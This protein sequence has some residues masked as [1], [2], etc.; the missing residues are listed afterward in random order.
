MGETGGR[1]GVVDEGVA[2][3]FGDEDG[4]GEDG[5]DGDGL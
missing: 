4:G 2:A 1:D 3:H 5:H